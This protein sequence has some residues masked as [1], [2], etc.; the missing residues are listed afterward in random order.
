MAPAGRVL[1][2]LALL[3]RDL[4]LRRV[5]VR[6]AHGRRE[7]VDSARRAMYSLFGMAAF[8]FVI[9]DVAFVS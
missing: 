7:W 2:I 3:V 5:A 1:L 8:A 9:L 6:R 4:R